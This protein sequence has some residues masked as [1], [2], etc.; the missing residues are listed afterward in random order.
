MNAF[1]T[2][3]GVINHLWSTTLSVP[4]GGTELKFKMTGSWDTN[5]G[6]TGFPYGIGVGNG[7][8]I[9]VSEGEWIITFNDIDG[10]Y[11]F[12]AK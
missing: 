7:S 8:N 4:A 9:P 1:N 11:A 2:V 5:W 12:T 3:D 10:S 6:G